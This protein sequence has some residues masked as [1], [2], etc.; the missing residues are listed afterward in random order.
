MD[1]HI[2]SIPFKW[3]DSD[4]ETLFEVYGKVVSAKI[5]IDKKTRQNKGF[6]FVTMST[7]E[8][9]MKAIEALN[10]FEFEERNITVTLS[11]PKEQVF[12]SPQRTKKLP[13]KKPTEWKSEKH[14][15]SLPPWL[16][17]EY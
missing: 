15:K 6:G 10:G 3:K 17:K 14:K 4:L 11:L 7:E 9:T 12:K 16:R 8:E 2:G 13:S 5:I 1:I